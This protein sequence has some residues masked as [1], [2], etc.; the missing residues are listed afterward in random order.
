MFVE[1]R[2]G[3]ICGVFARP[4]YEGQE[5]LPADHSEILEFKNSPKTQ[6][7]L[8]DEAFKEKFKDK[9]SLTP[10]ELEEAVFWLLKR[11]M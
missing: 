1:R 2:E 9:K 10:E 8:D 11:N 7:E 5:F 3:K 4:Q 6:A